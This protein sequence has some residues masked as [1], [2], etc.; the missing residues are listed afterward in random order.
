VHF[1]YWNELLVKWAQ[2]GHFTQD[3]AKSWGDGNEIDAVLSTRLGFDFNWSQNFGWQ[4]RLNPG[5][6]KQV[7]EQHADGSRLVL[8]EDGGYVIEK[9]GVVSIPKEVD[10]ML[11]GR[12][13]WED[14]FKPRLQFNPERITQAFVTIDG[15]SKRFDAGGY[16]LMLGERKQFYGLYCGS[17]LG[18]VRDWLGL[19]GMSYLMKDDERLFDEIIETVGEL[20]YQGTK[21]ILECG[22]KFDYAH[23]WEDIAYKSGPLVNPKVFQE[24]IGPQYRRITALMRS[25]GIS[26][27]SVDCDGK[28]DALIP[29]WLENG[30]N[31]MFPIEVGTW[32]ASLAP[33]REKYG[34]ELRG[35]GGVNKHVFG[36]EQADIDR[37]IERIRP[38]VDMG[39]YIPCP[40]HRL[41]IEANWGNVQYYCEKMRRLFG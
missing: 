28:I 4:M 40:D 12:T 5:I 29:T 32:N 21:A 24:K 16:E 22:V 23:F 30:V 10:H 11:K 18:V 25:Y 20:I 37:E 33:W 41:P 8:N 34:L 17:L 35:V 27:V 6:T 2:E 1:G 26:L 13:E 3:E 39:G 14:F 7:I 38:L 19:V 9:E 36:L 15:V 31:I